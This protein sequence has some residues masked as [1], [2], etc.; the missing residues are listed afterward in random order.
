MATALICRNNL[1]T[2]VVSAVDDAVAAAIHITMMCLAEQLNVKH[3]N[4]TH[5]PFNTQHTSKGGIKLAPNIENGKSKTHF[6]CLNSLCDLFLGL[7]MFLHFLPYRFSFMST[8]TFRDVVLSAAWT[9]QSC[10]PTSAAVTPSELKVGPGFSM[11]VQTSWD[12]TTSW[13]GESILITST[14]WASVTL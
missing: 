6:A 8:K 14:G 4:L 5:C 9:T 1:E 13:P 10:R 2:I 7:T 3:I 11:N 12:A